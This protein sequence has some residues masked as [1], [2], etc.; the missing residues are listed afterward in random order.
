MFCNL[1]FQ[2]SEHLPCM[3]DG[4]RDNND[5]VCPNQANEG[6]RR[7]QA[8]WKGRAKTFISPSLFR[9]RD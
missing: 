1:I 9:S 3:F 5:I 7:I 4:L 8:A 6:V 2:N